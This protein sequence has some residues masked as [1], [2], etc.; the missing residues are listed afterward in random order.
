MWGSGQRPENLEELFKIKIRLQK[1]IANAGVASRRK[2]EELIAGGHVTVNGEIV[3]ELGVKAGVRDVIEVDG[4]PIGRAPKKK[5]YIML[6][7][8]TGVVTTASD[9]LGRPTVLDFLPPDR[10]L[11]PVGRL[12]FDTSGLIFLTNDGDWANE[13]THPGGG[14]RK[15]YI[16][17]LRGEPTA[18]E[19]EKFRTGIRLDGRL[20]APAEIEVRTSHGE[21]RG[22]NSKG[23]RSPEAGNSKKVCKVRI[24]ITEGRNRQIRKM[25]E[26]IG[27]P[28]IDLKRI[29]IGG[30]KLGDLT[31]G[32]WRYLTEGEIRQSIECVI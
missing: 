26:A 19:L 6:H 18:K 14:I 16:A 15:T 17:N 10:R 8:P 29:A 22:N 7:K 3:T 30:V 9:E 25:C 21:N 32:R 23:K 20:T 31:E 12:D 24:V 13:L 4:V 27:H 28:V 5:T 11:F 2:A 1:I